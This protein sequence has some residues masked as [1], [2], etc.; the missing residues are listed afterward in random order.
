MEFVNALLEYHECY[1]YIIDDK[2]RYKITMKE[3]TDNGGKPPIANKMVN[4]IMD[5]LITDDDNFSISKDEL[6]IYQPQTTIDLLEVR[7]FVLD[8]FSTC[9]AL[10]CHHDKARD[11]TFKLAKNKYFG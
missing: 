6:K 7:N 4:K 9:Y 2:E 1:K 10:T 8:K 3:I 11:L 5:K